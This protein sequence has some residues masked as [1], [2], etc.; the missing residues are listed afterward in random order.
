MKPQIY[1]PMV[2]L[3]AMLTFSCSTEEIPQDDFEQLALPQAPATKQIEIEILEMINA[4]R[5][6]NGL[7]PMR[8]NTV[9]KSVAFTH[10]D[11]MVTTNDVSHENFFERRDM[12]MEHEKAESVSENV[13]Y[14]YSSARAVVD[15]WIASPGH[16]AQLVGDYTEFDISA[17]KNTEGRWFFTNM[18]IKR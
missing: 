12:L 8:Q 14:G 13:G 10:T 6:E 1:L 18:F 3:L 7:N 15:A 5:I 11:Y 4:Y 2:A 16:Q 17:E 9:V